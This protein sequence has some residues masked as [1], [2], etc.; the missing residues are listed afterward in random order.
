MGKVLGIVYRAI[1]TQLIHKAGYTKASVQTGTA[2]PIFF[3]YAQ[4]CQSSY[5]S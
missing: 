2:K 1:A 4:P 3:A 5:S